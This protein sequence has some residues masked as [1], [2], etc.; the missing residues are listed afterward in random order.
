VMRDKPAAK[1]ETALLDAWVVKAAVTPFAEALNRT[2]RCKLGVFCKPYAGTNDAGTDGCALRQR[3]IAQLIPQKLVAQKG[4]F[5]QW[6]GAENGPNRPKTGIY[7]GMGL[8]P[9]LPAARLGQTPDLL[10]RF[11]PNSLYFHLCFSLQTL[12]PLKK[13]QNDLDTCQVYTQIMG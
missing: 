11:L 12:H 10:S 7:T 8:E 2:L 4:G 3:G 6:A 5:C 13:V 1:M 9:G